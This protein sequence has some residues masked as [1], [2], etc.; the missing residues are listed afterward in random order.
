[1]LLGQINTTQNDTI[2]NKKT[3]DYVFTRCFSFNES[4]SFSCCMLYVSVSCRSLSDLTTWS[5]CCFAFKI[6]SLFCKSDNC[7]CSVFTISSDDSNCAT[8]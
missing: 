8:N 4:L 7:V 2:I 3:R 1:M 5:W 6:V